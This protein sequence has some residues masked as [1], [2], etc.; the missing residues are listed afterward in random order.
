MIF[1]AVLCSTIVNEIS[2][3]SKEKLGQLPDNIP[4]AVLSGDVST[5]TMIRMLAWRADLIHS[6]A[7]R[8]QLFGVFKGSFAS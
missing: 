5:T 8:V 1:A 3:K 2:I 6:F 4:T 7:V